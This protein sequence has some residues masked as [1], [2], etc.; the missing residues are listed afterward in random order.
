MAINKVIRN[1]K[2]GEEILL[3]LTGDTATEDV[4]FAGSTFHAANGEVKTGSFTLEN[5]MGAQNTLISRIKA[6]LAGKAAG[7]GSDAKPT[8]RKTVDITSNG[9]TEISPDDGFVLSGVTA[10]VNV[11]IPDGYIVP[12]G[13]KEI[14][15]NGT[16]DVTDK[17]S[18]VVSVP[19][20][21]IVLQNKEVTENGT[22]TADAGYDGLGQVIVNVP[23]G[24]GE[25][26]VAALLENTLTTLDNRNA[27]SLKSRA[28]QGS[29]KLVSVNLPSVTSMGT[30]AFYNCSGLLDVRMDKVTSI[31]SQCFYSCSKLQ[32]ADFGAV[33]SIAAQ[34]FNACTALTVL[35]LRKS[36][37][38]CT[39][40]NTNAV[41]NSGIGTGKGFVYVPRALLN[42][43]TANANWSAVVAAEEFRAIED[44]P[45]I[46]G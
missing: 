42:Q 43:Y 14:S 5:E 12:S 25:D 46:C 22:Y 2:N 1:T 29:T 4:V 31:P 37:G 34:A 45:E 30:Y 39:L 6:A 28:L 26:D 3:D 35:I 13:T 40:A 41:A 21:A 44:Y 16:Y 10:R 7:S 32:R 24:G 8:Q 17:K 20:R 18:V 23:T 27:T 36:D 33:G 9:T 11:P 19:E 15:A 38:I